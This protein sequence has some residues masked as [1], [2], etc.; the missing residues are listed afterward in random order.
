M[1]RLRSHHHP[2]PPSFYSHRTLCCCLLPRDQCA[3]IPNPSQSGNQNTTQRELHA[4]DELE[5]HGFGDPETTPSSSS[6]ERWSDRLKVTGHSGSIYQTRSQ[7]SIF[8]SS[9]VHTPGVCSEGPFSLPFLGAGRAW[10]PGE[11]SGGREAK[12]CQGPEGQVQV[13]SQS[14]G[15][16]RWEQVLGARNKFSRGCGGRH[17]IKTH[18]LLGRK[19]M[20]NLDSILKSRHLTLPTKV[21]I[22]KAMVFP[23]VMYGCESWTI[24]KV[25]HWRT[26]AFELWC[27]S[28]LLRVPWTERWSNQSILKEINPRYSLE[29]LMLKLKLQYF[30]HLIQRADPLEKT[31]T[32]G[33][34]EEAMA[35]YSTVHVQ[36]QLL[37]L[38]GSKKCFLCDTHFSKMFSSVIK[39]LLN[40]TL[41][42]E[43]ILANKKCER[44][45]KNNYSFALENNR[46]LEFKLWITCTDVTF[47]KGLSTRGM[48]IIGSCARLSVCVCSFSGCLP[49][50]LFTTHT[51]YNFRKKYN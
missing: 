4:L 20:T 42:S 31:L 26:D 3:I 36:T 14:P 19:A 21:L 12:G 2:S 28:R 38:R 13:P 29:G 22:V 24:K 9:M 8:W 39:F 50:K 41:D 48:L 35:N 1:F 5:R 43:L 45:L 40:T 37:S 32:L 34:F 7:V 25:E 49:L 11:G 6:L 27:W 18:L 10:E 33:K 44:T 47:S 30:G 46:T 17:E 23:V 51:T 15:L 16:G